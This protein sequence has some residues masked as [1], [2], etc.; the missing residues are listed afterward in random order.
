MTAAD[1]YTKFV[2][3]TYSDLN[4]MGTITGAA[5]TPDLTNG[6]VQKATISGVCNASTFPANVKAGST[7]II[8]LEQATGADTIS[9]WNA[10]YKFPGGVAPTLS[11]A[12]GKIGVITCVAISTT[13]AVVT[14]SLDH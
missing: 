3:Q 10:G 4:D 5:V 1:R 13:E 8:M 12:A 9:A 6:N 7:F 2:G 11:T 14:S